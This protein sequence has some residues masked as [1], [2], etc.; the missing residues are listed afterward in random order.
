MLFRDTFEQSGSILNSLIASNHS[1]IPYIFRAEPD[2]FPSLFGALTYM[3]TISKGERSGLLERTFAV[4]IS[5][6]AAIMSAAD[7]THYKK[8][9][10]AAKSN[11][12]FFK[13]VKKAATSREQQGADWSDVAIMLTF[14]KSGVDRSTIKY[15]L[16][17]VCGKF[18][19]DV[20]AQA[21]KC[22][23]IPTPTSETKT[24]Q[25]LF[26]CARC[27]RIKYCSAE[28]Q[29]S[30]WKWH[31]AFCGLEGMPKPE[32]VGL[33]PS[34]RSQTCLLSGGSEQDAQGVDLDG[35]YAHIKRLLD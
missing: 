6:L 30:D 26:A 14:E 9:H 11:K 19:C 22:M 12:A 10:E 20:G 34:W 3:L 23:D 15:L 32:D 4:V 7:A 5:V 17:Q 35:F 13:L 8:I 1:V 21:I 24:L 29:K 27:K 18:S 25:P 31:K 16:R 28:C 33:A 2:F